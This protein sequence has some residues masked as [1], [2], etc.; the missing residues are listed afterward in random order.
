LKMKTESSIREYV[1]S[2]LSYDPDTGIFRW[3]VAR[4]SYGGKAK[5]GALAGCR[6][7]RYHKIGID[8]VEYRASRLAWLIVH[9]RWPAKC[10]DHIN[11]DRFDN[12]IVNL[13]EA[14]QAQNMQN[15]TVNKT[16]STGIKGVGF[17]KERQRFYA[18][19]CVNYKSKHLGYFDN[20]G[21]AAAAYT[22]ASVKLHPFSIANSEGFS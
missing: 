15:K 3:K 2:I 1:L 9:G 16:S 10:I 4:N 6:R 8:G 5:P 12:R 20:I 11:R 7:D 14:T 21:D 13:R 17:C 18:R 19:I 22:Y